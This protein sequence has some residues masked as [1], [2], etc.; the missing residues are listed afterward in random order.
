MTIASVTTVLADKDLLLREIAES[1]TNCFKLSFAYQRKE[2][3]AYG[4]KLE[5]KLLPWLVGLEIIVFPVL[6][7]KGLQMLFLFNETGCLLLENV[8]KH[9]L[10]RR[11]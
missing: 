9:V 7:Q 1:P 6:L 3:L 10:E 5:V 8:F 2:Y 11:L 4:K